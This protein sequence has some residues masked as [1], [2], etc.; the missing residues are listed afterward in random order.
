M[1]TERSSGAYAQD[2]GGRGEK[3]SRGWRVRCASV[4]TRCFPVAVGDGK[5]W[6]FAAT[7]EVQTLR[8]V[9]GVVKLSASGHGTAEVT[10]TQILKRERASDVG[11]R[12]AV[13][14]CRL[15]PKGELWANRILTEATVR[16][17]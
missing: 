5:E 1:L 4:T 14:Y 17:M 7:S 13:T 11:S 6:R 3:R 8:L 16:Y 2:D 10:V 15:C 9:V 12:V